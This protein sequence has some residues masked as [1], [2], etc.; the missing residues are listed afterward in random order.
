M[1]DF[2][3]IKFKWYPGRERDRERKWKGI[4]YELSLTYKYSPWLGPY[5]VNY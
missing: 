2:R 4:H 3:E 1:E 5:G